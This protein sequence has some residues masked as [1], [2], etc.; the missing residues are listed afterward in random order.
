M[1]DAPY[2]LIVTRIIAAPSKGWQ[3]MTSDRGVVCPKPWRA[4][5]DKLER[6]PVATR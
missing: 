3:M 4:V 6:R 5:F 2:E 1:A